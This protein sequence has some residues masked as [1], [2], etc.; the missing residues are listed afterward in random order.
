MDPGTE[1]VSEVGEFG[2]IDRFR[3]KLPAAP[4]GQIWSGDDAAVVPG[5]ARTAF[6]TD[7]LVEGVDFDWALGG[8]GDAGWK[9]IAA[10]A[11]DVA[12]MGGRPTFCVA[13]LG[14]PPST[15]VTVV[16][17][18]LDG[19]VAAARR[20]GIET[21]GG[22]VSEAAQVFLAISMLGS[23]EKPVSR[24]GARI[25]DAIC[26]TGSL[27][28]AAAG[29]IALRRGLEGPGIEELIARQLRPEARVEEGLRLAEV[30]TAMIDVS[31]GFLADLVHV[32]DASGLG[33]DVDPDALPIDAH[34]SR[35]DVGVDPRELALTGGEDLELIATVPVERLAE[36]EGVVTRVGTIVE[37]ERSIGGRS[38]DRWERKGWQHLSE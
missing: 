19:M 27:G 23:V 5:T 29:L 26:V 9:A 8:P 28:G 2:L 35:V 1:R 4:D 31:D 34:L 10:N 30:A 38:L 16:D 25:G 13:A 36:V 11:S 17:G 18:L 15:E 3:S 20:W 32:L 6:T 37:A 21:V 24:S 33:C 22:D 7:V 14:L 12:A